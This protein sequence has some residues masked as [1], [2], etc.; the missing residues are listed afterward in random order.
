MC[1][2]GFALPASQAK[3]LNYY[4]TKILDSKP[5]REIFVNRVNNQIYKENSIIK[6]PKMAKTLEVI[7]REGE[8][9]FYDGSLTDTILDEI[10]SNGGI[11]TKADLQSYECLIKEPVSYQMRKAGVVLNSAPAPSCGVLLNFILAIMDGFEND[12]FTLDTDD[13][14]AMFSHR[15]IEACKFAFG[16]RCLIGDDKLMTQNDA[17]FSLFI[18]LWSVQKYLG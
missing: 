18:S 10:V 4:E 9:A 15:F 2:N 5:L 6:R 7:S 13:T 11:I 3:S 17:S 8:S 1:N 14:N 16:M 12:E